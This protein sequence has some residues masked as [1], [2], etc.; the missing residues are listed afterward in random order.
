MN[1]IQFVGCTEL[2]GNYYLQFKIHNEF[3]IYKFYCESVLRKTEQIIKFSTWKAL[4]QAKKKNQ[5]WWKQN[6]QWHGW[7]PEKIK[8]D[9]PLVRKQL[10]LSFNG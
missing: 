8:L 9:V 3:F 4:N 2:F 7:D 6:T 5:G 1:T 10:E